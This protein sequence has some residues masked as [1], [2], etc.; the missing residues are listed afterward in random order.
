MLTSVV[1]HVGKAVELG[2]FLSG[3]R[4]KY[5]AVLSVLDRLN[6]GICILDRSGNIVVSNASAEV[7][8]AAGDGL[9]QHHGKFR[10]HGDQ[11]DARFLKRILETADAAEGKNDVHSDSFYVDRFSGKLP[12]YMEIAPI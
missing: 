3:L 4:V 6:I 8:L 2:D 11:M 7:I 12:Y 9:Q 10:I 5:K 1:P